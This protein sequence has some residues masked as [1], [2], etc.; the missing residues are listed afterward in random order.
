MSGAHSMWGR[1]EVY[2]G[3]WWGDLKERDYLGHPSI[4]ARIIFR[5]ILKKW[6]VGI[7]T[8]LSWLKIGT[9]GG[10]L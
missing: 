10:H 1:G 9:G 5:L 7:W 4:G 3:F 8:G 2:I 6:D